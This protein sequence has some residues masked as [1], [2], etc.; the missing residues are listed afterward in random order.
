MK[1]LLA[2]AL[3]GVSGLTMAQTPAVNLMPDGSRDMYLGLGASV[4]PRYEGA[5]RQR[6]RALPLLQVQFSNGIF[7]SGMSAGWHLSDNPA[8]EYGPLLTIHPGRTEA[9]TGGKLGGVSDGLTFLPPVTS[10]DVGGSK[11]SGN[12]LQGLDE[13]DAR[14]SGG[15]FVNYY[16]GA[17]LRWNNTVLY[18][19]GRRGLTW[20]SSVQTVSGDL[21]S[22]HKLSFSAGFSAVNRHY[23]ETFFGVTA[24]EAARTGMPAYAPGAGIKDVFVGARW[25][26]ALSPSWIVTSSAR[27]ARLQGDAKDSPLVQRAT[28]YSIST[29][30]AYRF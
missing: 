23:N 4:Q 29:G 22:P 12:P 6:T 9:G 25:N 11:S 30:L 3:T 18:G 16:L 2:L 24:A 5:D 26:W 10:T 28:Q 7:L 1:K 14:L 8:I 20:E 13:I 27:V 19:A 15:A 17:G 21:A